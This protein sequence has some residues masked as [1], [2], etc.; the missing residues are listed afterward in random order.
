MQS[1]KAGDSLVM[2]F[3]EKGNEGKIKKSK[4]YWKKRWMAP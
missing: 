1:S 3:G 2:C 4:V